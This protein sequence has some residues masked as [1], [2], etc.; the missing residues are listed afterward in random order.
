[1]STKLYEFVT[2]FG[3]FYNLLAISAEN[4][5]C[6]GDHWCWFCDWK[7]QG[8]NKGPSAMKPSYKLT[9]QPQLWLVRVSARVDFNLFFSLEVSIKPLRSS[10]STHTLTS[11]FLLCSILS[12]TFHSPNSY[13]LLSKPLKTLRYIQILKWVCFNFFSLSSSICCLYMYW[14]VYLS[15]SKVEEKEND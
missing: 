5:R 12:I 13:L 2:Q 1:M 9:R 15:M 4:I 3:W 8:P 10:S 11:L 14:K 6:C 7:V